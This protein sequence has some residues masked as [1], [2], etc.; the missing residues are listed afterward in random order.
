[1]RLLSL[2]LTLFDSCLV[3][4]LV[5]SFP[6]AYSHTMFFVIYLQFVERAPEDVVR[7]VREKATEAEEKINLTKNRLAFLK[8]SVLVSQ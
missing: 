3:Y 6:L 8:S 1:M 7:G 4:E 5:H 2:I